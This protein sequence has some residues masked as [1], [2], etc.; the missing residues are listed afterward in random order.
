[1]SIKVRLLIAFALLIAFM[2]LLAVVGAWASLTTGTL[3]MVTISGGLFVAAATFLW[4]VDPLSDANKALDSG[5]RSFEDGEYS[6]RLAP[7]NCVEAQPLFDFFN[8][9]GEVFQKQSSVGYQKEL[10]LDTVVHGA[11]MAILLFGP[12][13]RV[14][15]ANPSARDLFRLGIPLP[16]LSYSALRE[17]APPR[18]GEALDL[19]RDVLFTELLDNDRQTF[20]LSHRHFELNTAPHRLVIVKRLTRELRRQEVAIWKKLIRLINHELNNSLAPMSSLLHS[21]RTILPVPEHHDKLERIFETM[22]DT[23]TRLVTFLED[24]AVFARLPKPNMERVHWGTFLAQLRELY[25][26]TLEN[27][28]R[29]EHGHFDPGQIQ[30][31]LINVLK[32]AH[33]AD[34]NPPVLRLDEDPRG[35]TLIRISDRGKGMSTEAMEKALLPF[36]STKKSGTGLGLPLCR[37]VVES[38]GG[39]MRLQARKEGGLVV[40]IWLP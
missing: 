10:L 19:D 32:N 29:A 27:R 2:T 20:H 17:A 21:A 6:F 25:A 15:L 30:Q 16:G 26:F 9:L 36:Y 39:T 8:R 31:A 24:Y 33:E 22:G 34:P 38:H 5:I 3:I 40:S 1:M 7:S 4:V 37:E 13:D 23:I 12:T 35:G 11:P 28:L 14:I 18:F